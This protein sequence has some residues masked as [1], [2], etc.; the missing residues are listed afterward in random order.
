MKIR[1]VD[2]SN[3]AAVCR[4]LGVETVPEE[5]QST[6][7]RSAASFQ[8]GAVFFLQEVFVREACAWLVMEEEV[9]QAFL[10]A[11]DLVAGRPALERLAWHSHWLLFASGEPQ[12]PGSWP[13]IPETAHPAAPMFYALVFLSGVEA[14]RERHRAR[15]IAE[16]VTRDTL[17]DLALWVR[18]HKTHAGVWGLRQKSWLVHHFTGDL[19]KLGRL[20]FLPGVFDHPFR[21]FR[22]KQDG[23]VRLLAE[24]GRRF[25]ADGEFASADR[26]REAEAADNWTSSL[27]ITPDTI[28]GYPADPRGWVCREPVELP[29]AEW[30]PVLA[31]GDAVLTVH[32][33]ATGPMKHAD[34]GA[35]FKC[36]VRFFAEHFPERVYP[37][38]TCN[39]W[40]LDPQLETVLP[41]QS[42]IVRFL[43]EWYLHPVENATDAQTI[44]RVFG[45]G[46]TSIDPAT[47]P[48][49]TSLQRAI[50]GHMRDGGRWRN[51][52]GVIFA[53][54]LK[55][56]GEVYRGSAG[57]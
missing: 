7:H 28:R 4:A 13:M 42:N 18:E 25:R 57:S 5:W 43:R 53:A 29:A 22:K 6:W 2:I 16:D 41:E 33:P 38:F 49:E 15:G 21:A 10:Q 9:R 19:F 14:V 11:L 56:G 54:D 36:A 52:G 48:Q 39:S 34:C 50:A 26:G 1:D 23:A 30:L 47:A 3:V 27:K 31:P 40:L 51:S 37:A 44:E 12:Q 17:S 35:S 20:Q 45:F 46:V 8:P 32:I 55:W 24:A